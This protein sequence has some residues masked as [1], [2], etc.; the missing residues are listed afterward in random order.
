MGGSTPVHLGVTCVGGMWY[1]C[2]RTV[3]EVRARV[4]RCMIQYMV[5]YVSSQISWMTEQLR[6]PFA[7]RAR[8]SVYAPEHDGP[9]QF[10][11][12]LAF[13]GCS[14]QVFPTH[15]DANLPRTTFPEY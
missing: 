12:P 7:E 8:M 15:A 6:S 3:R 9:K 5:L 11:L 1:L 14:L 10:S 2:G 13:Y 4:H